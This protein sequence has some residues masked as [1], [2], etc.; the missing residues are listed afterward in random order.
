MVLHSG[1]FVDG[2]TLRIAIRSQTEK[3]VVTHTFHA[4][5]L[6]RIAGLQPHCVCKGLRTIQ[7]VS[8]GLIVA[9]TPVTKSSRQLQ[10]RTRPCRGPAQD[11]PRYDVNDLRISRS[12]LCIPGMDQQFCL[13]CRCSTLHTTNHESAATWETCKAGHAPQLSL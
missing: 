12:C 4:A 11:A 3:S 7:N 9:R 6:A 5:V 1:N 10:S 8:P 13:Q 2:T